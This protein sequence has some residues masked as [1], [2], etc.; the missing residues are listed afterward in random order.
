M[1]K[2]ELYKK[3]KGG[4]VISCQALE[5][6]PLHSS[7]I[8]GSMA[9]AAM[10]EG[11]VG[12]RCN[13]VPDIT[14][15]KKIVDLPLIGI[16]KQ[17]YE[18]SEVYITPTAKEIEALIDLKVDI[19]AID[20]TDRLRTGGKTLAEIFLPIREKYPNQIFMADC[21]TYDDAVNAEKL[22]FDIVGT[23]MVGC[24]P[25]TVGAIVPPIDLMKRLVEDLSIPV[26]AEGG[27]HYPNQLK[28]SI[29]TD[30]LCAVVGGAITRPQEIARRFISAIK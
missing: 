4:L 7:F 15:I 16:I 10:Q 29:D 17:V 21:S 14:E 28:E 6:E 9:L 8:M 22:G 26:I 25:K 24:T 23:T 27:I 30:I 1:K 3:L 20:A 12:I 2:E 11:A 19:I 13:T 18:D 5:N